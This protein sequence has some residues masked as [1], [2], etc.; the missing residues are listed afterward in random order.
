MGTFT[1]KKIII[2]ANKI[3]FE[4]EPDSKAEKVSVLTL[5]DEDTHRSKLSAR[6]PHI[7]LYPKTDALDVRIG[8]TKDIHIDKK[9][10]L[11]V[12]CSTGRNAVDSAELHLRSATAGLR[13]RTADAS[14]AQGEAKLSITK[15]PGVIEFSG[16]AAKSKIVIRIPYD[17]E[18][19][20]RRISIGLDVTYNTA[21]G[22]FEYFSNPS[23]PTELALDVNVHDVFKSSFLIST[24]KIRASKGV[25][26][27]VLGI[28]LEGTDRFSVQSSTSEI[29]PMIV[30]PQQ[31]AQVFYKIKRKD[32]PNGRQPASE[33]KPLTLTVQYICIFETAISAIE[34]RFAGALSQTKFNALKS[35]LTLHLSQALRRL[36]SDFFTRVALLCEI[37]TPD[38]QFIGWISL[39]DNLPPNI[40]ND[41]ERWLRKWHEESSM[42]SLPLH[43]PMTSLPDSSTHSITI[44]VPLPRLQI[45]HTIS[46]SLPTATT[47]LFSTGT[48]IPAT[49][50]VSHTRR[51]DSP[52]SDS[53]LEF[54][55]DIDAPA[56]TWLVGGQR[57]TKFKA[58]EG[59]TRMWTIML[60]PLK[61]GRLL[62]PTMEVRLADKAAANLTC[63]TF[64][65]S[66]A[67]AVDV[68]SDVGS[69]TVGLTDVSSGS[70]PIL[71][72]SQRRTV[73][74]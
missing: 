3:S 20:L 45:L 8:L 59:E 70:E 68:I 19:T 35:L 58:A 2:K 61:C 27:R 41:L 16:V 67:Q 22:R 39:L 60:M 26:L 55:Y 46:L 43:E 1:V 50:T 51:W 9:R 30:F 17:L 56:D 73:I 52:F 36:E 49:V 4:F 44:S 31:E 53:P 42:I 25:P 18:D 6:M 64:Y 38:F 72:S 54:I 71:I 24:F 48:L 66:S 69:T 65:A 13:L 57:R 14:L 47:P 34:D 63:D 5:P 33:E 12:E 29:T 40:S 7:L 37:R 21:N 15:A 23:I 10:I 11:E 28:N 74:Q 32:A 62:L